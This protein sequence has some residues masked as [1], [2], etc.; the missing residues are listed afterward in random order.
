MTLR[1]AYPIVRLP[2]VA[3]TDAAVSMVSN[4]RYVGSIASFTADRNYT[5]PAGTAGDFIEVFLTTGDDA[6]ELILLGAPGVSINGGPAAT[7]WSRLFIDNEFARFR[8]H[9]T[10]D[11][12]VEVDGRVKQNAHVYLNTNA[13]SAADSAYTTVPFDTTIQ[14]IGSIVNL[15]TETLTVRRAGMYAIHASAGITSATTGVDTSLILQVAINA[16]LPTA[17]V[18]GRFWDNISATKVIVGSGVLSIGASSAIVLQL[19]HNNGSS[20]TFRGAEACF[21][22]IVEL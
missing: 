2:E 7:E 10:N 17:A 6:F 15:A 3:I 4:R 12:R 20:R 16:T 5:L 11:W 1:P 9:A 22:R 8:C 13:G 18:L 14:D 19:F 21:M